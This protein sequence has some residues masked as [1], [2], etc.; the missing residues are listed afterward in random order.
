MIATKDSE[1]RKGDNMKVIALVPVKLNNERLP[2]K[3]T[4]PFDN[5]EPLIHYILTTLAKVKRCEEIYVYCS[6]ARI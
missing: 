5:G 4:K 6:D 3:N 1:L 2:G